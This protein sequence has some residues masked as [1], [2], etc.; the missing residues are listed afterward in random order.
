MPE[1]QRFVL[2]IAYQAGPD[3]RIKKGVD[4]GRDFFSK[5][6]LELACWSY[7]RSGCPQINAF[8]MDGTEDCAEPVE[9]FIW[10]WPDWDVGDGVVV[11][12]GDWCL[13]AILSPRMWGLHKDGKVNGL[14]PEGTARRRRVQK[15]GT[16]AVA[17]G[18]ADMAGDDDDEFSEL[19]DAAFSKVAL[20]GA[21]A[22]GVPRFMISKQ[23][24]AAGLVD[25]DYVR[26]LIAKAEPDQ[27]GGERVT[28]P[29]GVTLSGSPADI[30]AF[31]HKAARRADDPG[32]VAKAKLSSADLNDLPDSAFAF[33]E[34]GGKK[35][36]SGKT[37]PRSLRHFAIHDKAHADNAAARIAQGAKFG[38][39]AKPKVE[40]A[41]RKFGEKKV[42]KEAAVADAVTKDMGPELDEGADGLDPTIPLAAPDEDAPGDP[43][44]PGSPAW[45]SIDAATA[46]KW[47]SI[48]VRLKNA[49]CVMAE[50][51][52]TEAATADPG[53]AEA[54]FDLQDAM[55]AVDYVIDTLAGFA[56]GEQAEADLSGEAMDAIGKALAGFDLGP[57]E[58]VEGLTAVT[59]AGRV[60]SAAN[61]AAIRQA[62]ASLQ[63]VL[64]SLPQAPTAPDGTGQPVAKEQETGMPDPTLSEDVTAAAGE[65]PMGTAEP[66]PGAGVPVVAT[67]P[68]AKA[69][70]DAGKPAQVAVYDASGNLVGVADPADITP[71]ANVA[72][73]AKGD[74]PDEA[75]AAEPPADP[76]PAADPADM[77][78]APPA[79]AGTPAD[80]VAKSGD[81][82][83]TDVRAVLKSIVA[84]AVAE[85]LE[86]RPPAEDIAKQADVAGLG[87]KFEDLL[88]RVA[89]VEEQPAAPKVFTNGQT[90]PADQLRGQDRGT[91]PRVDVTKARERKAALA[92]ADGPEQAVIA[93]QMQQDAIDAWSALT[94][95]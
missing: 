26:G 15:E 16:V 30:A 84:D 34:S 65:K 63:G 14:S 39:E 24:G 52:L 74:D 50:R 72:A 70:G 42:S 59:K 77:T 94:G 17:K 80:D 18:S 83:T 87:K 31:I 90:P 19:V 85:I 69:G 9:S 1:E 48:A 38:D 58:A 8:H 3:P 61:E 62:T 10:R 95:R 75:A 92:A 47:T 57:L 93:K 5:E 22:N 28:M 89:K 23:A 27:H 40:A 13:G 67:A 2:G 73:P 66:A 43:T 91:A 54:A 78:P 71:L 49:L 33:I 35:D 7:M 86:G 51:E 55:C 41:Q 37:T 4:G 36:E 32:D 45:E 64:A 68:V 53:D 25:P 44:D 60:L 46:R 20:V 81:G 21:P 82:G 6:A 11:K 88:V 56:V 12:D 79:D 76:A 29:S